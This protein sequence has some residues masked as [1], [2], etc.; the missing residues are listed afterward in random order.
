MTPSTVSPSLR[1]GAI[2]VADATIIRVYTDT[3]RPATSTTILGKSVSYEIL[4]V[5]TFIN[6]MIP[7]T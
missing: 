1:E 6:N 5:C 2:S 7:E 4:Y 3:Q